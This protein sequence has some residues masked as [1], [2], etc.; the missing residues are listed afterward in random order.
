MSYVTWADTGEPDLDNVKLW[1][2]MLL[3]SIA[4]EKVAVTLVVTLAVAAFAGEKLMTV[5]AMVSTFQALLAGVVSV[6]PTESMAL[7][8]K[9]WEPSD[10]L[11]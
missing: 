5:G 7:T 11:E 4:S 3:G 10:R 2:E 6:F 1:A 9:V 8:L